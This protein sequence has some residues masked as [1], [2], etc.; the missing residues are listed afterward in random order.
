MS[1]K[2]T[3]FLTR[4]LTI[5]RGQV[6]HEECWPKIWTKGQTSLVLK[7]S[8][9][10]FKKEMGWVTNQCFNNY[11]VIF[12]YSTGVLPP[13]GIILFPKEVSVTSETRH[14][15]TFL[16]FFF[17]YFC[18]LLFLKDITPRVRGADELPLRILLENLSRTCQV[19]TGIWAQFY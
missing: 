17:L 13:K 9:C 16:V 1:A 15:I 5:L 19:R 12:S 18:F 6:V 14:F 2:H 4:R 11:R 7:N 3:R 10:C 8:A